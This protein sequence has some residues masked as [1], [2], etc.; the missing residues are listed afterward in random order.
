MESTNHEWIYNGPIFLLLATN[1]FFLVS[2][3]YVV[4]TKLRSS[5]QREASDHQKLRAAKA[6]LVIIPLLGINYLITIVGPSDPTSVFYFIFVH[7][8]A[9]LLSSQGLLVTLPYC[10]FNTEVKG[11]L[12]HHWNRWRN[13]RSVLFENMKCL[14]YN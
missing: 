9:I 3:F 5:G 1:A 4:V 2:I 7:F 12:E 13:T 11:I 14:S 8:R 10:F 6:L